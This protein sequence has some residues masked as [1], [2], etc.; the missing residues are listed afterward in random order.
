MLPAATVRA[1]KDETT[2]EAA[3][4]MQCSGGN[5]L[6]AADAWA[7][8]DTPIRWRHVIMPRV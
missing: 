7:G 6:V 8:L 1:S 2:G 3:T 4:P 5:V